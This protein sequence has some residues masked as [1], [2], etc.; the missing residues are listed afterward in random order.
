MDIALI[1]WAVRYYVLP[2]YK[3]PEFAIPTDDPSL[4][5]YHEWLAAVQALPAVVVSEKGE[6]SVALGTRIVLFSWLFS[7]LSRFLR[8]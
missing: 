7:Q 2:L 1:P 4:A 8:E 5:G 3:G 6:F